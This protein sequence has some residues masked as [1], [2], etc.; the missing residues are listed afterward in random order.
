MNPA[1]DFSWLPVTKLN[2]GADLRLPLHVVEGRKPGPTLGLS[3]MLHGNEPAPSLAII[4]AVLERLDPAELSGRV[5]AV[6]VCN[7]LGAGALS[8]HTPIDGMNMNSAFC[9]PEEGGYV[10]PVKSV[11]EEI[12]DVLTEGF[13]RELDYQ[14]DFHCGGGGVSAHMV[15]FADHPDALAMA[16]AFNMR[17][18]LRD[19]WGSCQMWGMSE[20]LGVTLIVAECGGGEELHREWV[21][22][23]VRG[24]FNVMRSLGMLPG[25]P[26]RL[27]RQYVVDN[28][29]GHH[30][31]LTILRPR[32]AGLIVPEPA[33][34]AAASF[35]GAPVQDVE[36]LGQLV[37][38][39]DLAVRQTFGAPFRH[40]L[41]L[42]AV[43]APAWK[44]PGEIAYILADAEEAQVLGR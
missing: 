29:S 17:I 2:N 31:N 1:T 38:P 41:L 24:T 42:A 27:D 7:P 12:A 36:L 18:L 28:T 26:D 34:S 25:E 6:P 43:V 22:R 3:G 32:E 5:M 14:I 35:A 10:Q 40:T 21:D 9:E 8:R 19:E 20:R 16:R 44:Q 37:S 23:G 11:T 33:A 4:R 30:H 15:E 13:L 39:Y